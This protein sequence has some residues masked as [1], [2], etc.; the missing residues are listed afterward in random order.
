MTIEQE[1][2][3]RELTDLGARLRAFEASFRLSSDEF[4]Q[5]YEAGELGDSAEFM[6]WAFFYDMYVAVHKIYEK[7]SEEQGDVNNT[8]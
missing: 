2:T 3:Q 7:L 8:K 5:H 4:Y 6:E 1:C